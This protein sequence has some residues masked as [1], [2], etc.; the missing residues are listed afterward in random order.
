MLNLC[1][2]SVVSCKSGGFFLHLNWM[3]AMIV[4]ENYPALLTSLNFI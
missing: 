4:S 1:F 3:C 2:E